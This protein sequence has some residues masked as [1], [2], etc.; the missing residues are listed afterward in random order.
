MQCTNTEYVNLANQFASALPVNFAFN[1]NSHANT[2]FIVN[3]NNIC[4]PIPPVFENSIQSNNGLNCNMGVAESRSKCWLINNVPHSVEIHN[5][6][7]NTVVLGDAPAMISLS[8]SINQPHC[9]GSQLYCRTNDLEKKTNTFLL[10]PVSF[11]NATN[12]TEYTCKVL[13]GP[14]D[15]GQEYEFKYNISIISADDVVLYSRLLP[16]IPVCNGLNIKK[17]GDG[18][19]QRIF[20]IKLDVEKCTIACSS[21]LNDP[22]CNFLSSVGIFLVGA[23]TFISILF[24]ISASFAVCSG[25]ILIRNYIEKRK[26]E[27]QERIELRDKLEKYNKSIE[28]NV[29]DSSVQIIAI[30]GRGS[31]G[32]VF[33]AYL[34][35]TLVALKTL[36]IDDESSMEEY[37]KEIKLIRQLRHPNIMQL[38]GLVQ[39]SPSN[40]RYIA[41]ELAEHGNL[42][43]FMKTD[44]YSNLAVYAKLNILLDVAKGMEYLHSKRIIHR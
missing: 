7:N 21:L 44:L 2:S 40:T 9:L 28:I 33:K 38:L 16:R 23:F 12:T 36:V 8:F 41:C 43:S 22:K 30:I 39:T 31:F 37:W 24:C 1:T 13:R 15:S 14:I 27:K 5:T 32:K 25:I 34:N 29:P 4:G 35:S 20:D 26:L 19:L 17:P 42:K 3:G 6:N 18:I 11:S 10:N